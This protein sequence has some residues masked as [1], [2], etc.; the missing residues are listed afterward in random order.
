[1]CDWL[2]QNSGVAPALAGLDM[3]MPG[4]TE[5]I[6]LLGTSYWAYELSTSILNGSVPLSRLDDM[7]TRIV[8]AW[9]QLGQD[10]EFP[11]PN[12]S[13][14]TNDT[15]GPLYPGALLS[16]TGVVNQH[17]NVEGNHANVSKEISR[18]SITLLKNANNAL[19][20]SKNATLKVFGTDQAKNP[21]GINSCSS[22]AC[23]EGTL[24]M[25]WGSGTA[26]YPS[27]PSRFLPL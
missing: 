10:S 11:V 21:N 23:N 16:P 20:L 15:T 17:V 2:S 14:W 22:K 25:G 7:V 9:Y 3:S 27:V 18:D 13:A 8:A 1:M 6:P 26:N 24:G 4:D 19:P 5:P 12:F